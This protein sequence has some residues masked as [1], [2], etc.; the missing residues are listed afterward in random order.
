MDRPRLRPSNWPVRLL[1]V[2]FRCRNR[3]D[4]HP[5]H[6][7]TPPFR[8]D[9]HTAGETDESPGMFAPQRRIAAH[10]SLWANGRHERLHRTLKQDAATPS[11]ENLIEQQKRFS[12]FRR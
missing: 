9:S 5:T 10:L 3:L 11:S 8:T 7:C 6:S 1:A 4:P 12:E 2:G